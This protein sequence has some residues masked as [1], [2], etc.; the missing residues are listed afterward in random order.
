MVINHLLDGMILQ[1]LEG[2]NHGLHQPP[3]RLQQI[4]SSAQY[5][6]KTLWKPPEFRHVGTNTFHVKKSVV[7]GGGRV[8]FLGGGESKRPRGVFWLVKKG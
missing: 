7:P 3:T 5:L 1:V 4:G 6:G 2:N 8:F